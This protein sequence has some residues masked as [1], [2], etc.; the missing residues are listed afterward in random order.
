MSADTLSIHLVCTL[1]TLKSLKVNMCVHSPGI[2][3]VFVFLCLFPL[4]YVHFQSR[5]GVIKPQA[6]LFFFTKTF[7]LTHMP[8]PQIVGQISFHSG[9]IQND[10]RK[11]SK[12]APVN[13][14]LQKSHYRAERSHYIS[15]LMLYFAE[16]MQICIQMH[17]IITHRSYH[18][19]T[20]VIFQIAPHQ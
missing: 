15:K 8:S 14:P 6:Q 19:I 16:Q 12:P 2:W 3:F 5:G 4:F 11:M 13:Q 9:L 17:I 7:L 18:I 1:L 20:Q 10:K